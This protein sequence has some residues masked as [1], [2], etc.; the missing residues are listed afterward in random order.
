MSMYSL[1]TGT[2]VF[3]S[4]SRLHVDGLGAD[5]AGDPV[6]A[7]QDPAAQD[8]PGVHA[9]HRGEA[10]PAV[11]GETGDDHPHLVGVGVDEDFF[12]GVLAPF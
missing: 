6:L 7:H 11:S 2:A 5:D 10:E 4:S 1:S 8:H 12:A 3:R 9:A